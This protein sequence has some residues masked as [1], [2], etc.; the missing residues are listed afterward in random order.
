MGIIS[1]WSIYFSYNMVDYVFEDVTLDV[2]LDSGVLGIISDIGKGK[3]TL[4]RL[5][6]GLL[7]PTRGR[8]SILG[9]DT[10]KATKN[11][12]V[13]LHRRTSFAFQEAFLISNISVYDNLALPLM[14]NFN[15]DGKEIEQRIDRALEFFGFSHEKYSMPLDLSILERKLISI[16]RAFIYN[17][18]IVF[19][20]S[21]FSGLDK[22]SILRIIELIEERK[23][24]SLIVLTDLDDNILKGICDR[25]IYIQDSKNVFYY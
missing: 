14:Y 11:D 19:M 25:I 20:D 6:G 22:F 16:S 21:P 2:D 4:I 12:L 17:P 8:V 23:N 1:L 13:T 24:N 9:I 10:Q 15:L 18:R 5:M 7:K 3:S